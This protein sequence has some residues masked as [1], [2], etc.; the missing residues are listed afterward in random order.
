MRRRHTFSS[1]VEEVGKYEKPRGTGRQVRTGGITEE[2]FWQEHSL[3]SDRDG[4]KKPIFARP[5]ARLALCYASPHVNRE[6][7]KLRTELRQVKVAVP[8]GLVGSKHKIMDGVEYRRRAAFSGRRGMAVLPAFALASMIPFGGTVALLRLGAGIV[9]GGGETSGSTSTTTIE[10]TPTPDEN[11]AEPGSRPVEDD[12]RAQVIT[13]GSLVTQPE[14][15]STTASTAPASINV[16]FPWTGPLSKAVCQ[17][18]P[19]VVTITQADYYPDTGRFSPVLA[20]RRQTGFSMG[21]DA[22]N[23]QF[24]QDINTAFNGGAITPG[25]LGLGDEFNYAGSCVKPK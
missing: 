12:G 8:Y 19:E 6:A 15:G 1:Q 11:A 4:Q 7:R 5:L 2:R 3:F 16:S 14:T 17:G 10:A 9:S 18:P 23:Q 20:I 22:G 24:F 13:E 21:S 25:T